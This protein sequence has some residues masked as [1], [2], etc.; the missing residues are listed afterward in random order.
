[1]TR[2]ITRTT[3]GATPSADAEAAIARILLGDSDEMRSVRARIARVG[4]G[5]A[6]TIV[7]G[8]SGSGKECVA[9]ALHAAS[10]RRDGPFVAVNCGAI[11]RELIESELFGHE[12]GSFTGAHA[13]RA[14]RFEQ[15][16]GGTLFLDEIGDMPLDMQVKLLRVIEERAV[17]RVGG[18]RSIAVDVRIVS[19]THRDLEAAIALGTFR[20]DLFYRLAVVPVHLPPLSARVGDLPLLIDHFLERAGPRRASVAFDAGAHERLRAHG[21]AGNVRELR[22]LVERAAILHPGETLGARDV[23]ALLTRERRQPPVYVVE[24]PTPLPLPAPH[25]LPPRGRVIDLTA[26]TARFERDHITAALAECGGVVAAA[27]RQL[28]LRRT[29][30][31]EKMRRYGLDRTDAHASAIGLISA[32]AA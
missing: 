7:T 27:A 20:E 2:T 23:D 29:T 21:W 13:M 32:R 28:G 4:R 14:G 17:E 8:P 6:S 25:G 16:H 3:A 22:N 18:T 11:P 19:A 30:L 10:D 9:R 24:A 5:D 1:M 12:R 31:I 26:E 15:A